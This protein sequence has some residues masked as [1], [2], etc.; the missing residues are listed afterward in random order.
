MDAMFV[1][2]LNPHSPVA[3]WEI[4]P[5][6]LFNGGYESE[7]VESFDTLADAREQEDEAHCQ[8]ESATGDP[9]FYGVYMVMREQAIEEAGMVPAM[10]LTDFQTF[11]DALGLVTIIN[12]VPEMT[13][14]E[15]E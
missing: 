4:K 5:C 12:G 3:G 13:Y 7:H 9:V 1:K 6:L 11:D 15:D 2:S 14:E 8:F 10:H